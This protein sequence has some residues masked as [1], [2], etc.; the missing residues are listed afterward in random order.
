MFTKFLESPI[1]G[2]DLGT[3]NT[4]VYVKGQGI[5]LSEP[6]VVA[7]HREKRDVLAIGREAKYMLGRTPSNIIAVR[8]LKEGVIADFEMVEKMMRYFIKKT[9][10]NSFAKPNI[11]VGIPAGITE[12]EKRAVRE[13]I[14]QGVREIYLIE[15]SLAAAIGSRMPI[16]EPSGNMIVDIGGGTT[17]IS[18]ISFGSMVRS[19]TLRVGGDKFD[20][21]IIQYMR[22][23]FGVII[24]E[25]T[26]EDIKIKVG[27]VYPK[28]FDYDVRMDVKGRDSISGLPKVLEISSGDIRLALQDQANIILRGIIDTLEETPPE[29]AADVIDRGIVLAGGGAL[30]EGLKEFVQEST[31]VPVIISDNP[32][33]AIVSGAGK[34][35]EE[36]LKS[37]KRQF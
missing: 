19:N 6:S 5:V 21:A 25:R 34:Y 27:N 17:E 8:P 7:V 11:A 9:V 33:T 22:K 3:A 29:L 12:V 26:A 15:E 14:Q 1:L 10:S 20:E 16:Q 30:L 2:I 32:L 18:V 37:K 36:I 4:L 28:H 13:S 24:G 31:Q 35:L 23:N